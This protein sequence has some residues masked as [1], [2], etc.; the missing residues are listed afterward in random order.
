MGVVLWQA[1][2]NEKGMMKQKR[3]D[4]LKNRLMQRLTIGGLVIPV[5]LQ[6]KSGLLYAVTVIVLI[7]LRG[8]SLQ[9]SLPF[10]ILPPS[11]Q[12]TSKLKSLSNRKLAL[13]VHK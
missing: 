8:R 13:L 3:G 4:G 6:V 5:G 12:V 1:L 2:N 7:L 9:E 10:L 11:K